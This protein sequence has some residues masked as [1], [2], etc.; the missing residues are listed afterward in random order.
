[1]TALHGGKPAKI[2]SKLFNLCSNTRAWRLRADSVEGAM[3]SLPHESDSVA[4]PHYHFVYTAIFGAAKHITAQRDLSLR[5]E[6]LFSAYSK[7][8]ILISGK[9]SSR[10]LAT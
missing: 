7:M 3:K 1:M 2:C 9:L 10:I 6:W 8:P 4:C 5:S